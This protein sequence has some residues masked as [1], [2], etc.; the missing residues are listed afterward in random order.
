ML[1]HIP[2]ARRGFGSEPRPAG[3]SPAAQNADLHSQLEEIL[4]AVW[5]AEADW[6]FNDRLDLALRKRR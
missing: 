3:W 6:R 1:P 2:Y 4:N 5:K